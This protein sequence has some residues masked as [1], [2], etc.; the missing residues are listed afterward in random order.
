M[1]PRCKYAEYDP[2]FGES[3][4][5]KVGKPCRIICRKCKAGDKARRILCFLSSKKCQNSD[6]TLTR[7]PLFVAPTAPFVISFLRRE[8]DK[9]ITF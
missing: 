3:L 2:Y 4:C 9:K 5:Q 6:K 1:S 7:T 8:N